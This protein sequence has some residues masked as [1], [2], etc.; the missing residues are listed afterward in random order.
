MFW[1]I[2][3]KNR[4][5]ISENECSFSQASKE[6]IRALY[7]QNEADRFGVLDNG[8]F[9]INDIEYDFK[10][11]KQLHKYVQFKTA[12]LIFDGESKNSIESW[13]LGF[14]I[15]N[16]KD[17]EKYIMHITKNHEIYFIAQRF[18][19]NSNKIDERKV[20]LQ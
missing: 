19:L 7:F 16:S 15:Y 18:D 1:I 3:Y 14:E 6:N 10:I 20:R 17:Y 4:K 5:S 8:H 9:F 13:N 12:S 11:S 2:D